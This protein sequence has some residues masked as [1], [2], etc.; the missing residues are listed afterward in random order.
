MTPPRIAPSGGRRA[1]GFIA[2]SA[3]DGVEEL[4]LLTQMRRMQE[5]KQSELALTE[6]SRLG[7]DRA[8]DEA[9]RMPDEKSF[10]RFDLGR[11]KTASL[12]HVDQPV[13]SNMTGEILFAGPRQPVV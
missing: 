4:E 6:L 12:H 5:L 13:P 11:T 2:E 7:G 8:C 10:L 1:A 3:A 9:F